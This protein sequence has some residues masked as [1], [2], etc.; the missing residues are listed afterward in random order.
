MI[1]I[2]FIIIGIIIL[3]FKF[4]ELLFNR[5]GKSNK[6]ININSYNFKNQKNQNEIKGGL[7]IENT[8]KCLLLQKIV[9]D[10]LSLNKINFKLSVD[11]IF[12]D[13]QKKEFLKYHEIKEYSM[14]FKYLNLNYDLINN[15]DSNKI[16]NLFVQYMD[17]E[18]QINENKEELEEN[19]I[20]QNS[21]LEI[22]KNELEDI[23]I[24]NKISKK[25]FVNILPSENIQFSN[26]TIKKINEKI[27]DFY[28]ENV[29]IK[30]CSEYFNIIYIKNI[31]NIEELLKLYDLEIINKKQARIKNILNLFEC[32]RFYNLIIIKFMSFAFFKKNNN[33]TIII[34][35]IAH[36]KRF[37]YE[38][39][40][41]NLNSEQEKINLK[42]FSNFPSIDENN[43]NYCIDETLHKEIFDKKNL[44]G[45]EF[46]VKIINEI[47][48]MLF[49][50]DEEKEI[51]TEL[52]TEINAFNE[53]LS[54]IMNQNINL[55]DNPNQIGKTLGY[56][57]KVYI[58]DFLFKRIMKYTSNLIVDLIEIDN[59]YLEINDNLYEIF[60]EKI[61]NSLINNINI[62]SFE[63]KKIDVFTEI[64]VFKFYFENIN[65]NNE[66][67]DDTNYNHL[68]N[69]IVKIVEEKAYMNSYE[70]IYM[71]MQKF[72]YDTNF[73]QTILDLIEEENKNIKNN[74]QILMIDFDKK[75][76][77]PE[78]F[79]IENLQKIN[80]LFFRLPGHATIVIIQKNINE[81]KINLLFFNPHEYFTLEENKDKNK[82]S[83]LFNNFVDKFKKLN[84]E[85]KNIHSFDSKLVSYKNLQKLFELSLKNQYIGMC[86]ITSFL[87]TYLIIHISLSIDIDISNI[88]LIN[89]YIFNYFNKQLFSENF[90]FIN[91]NRYN[92][93]EI[94]LEKKENLEEN[95]NIINYYD[96][97]NN[98]NLLYNNKL[99]LLSD[100]KMRQLTSKLLKKNNYNLNFIL[101]FGIL[102]IKKYLNKYVNLNKF[103]PSTKMFDV[104]LSFSDNDILQKI[105][106]RIKIITEKYSY[107]EK[108]LNLMNSLKKIKQNY[109]LKTIYDMI[110]QDYIN[111][112]SIEYLFYTAEQKFKLT[113]KNYI[114]EIN[115]WKNWNKNKILTWL[116]FI[117]F[118][119]YFY[120][121]YEDENEFFILK[122]DNINNNLYKFIY[123]IH[124]KF[125]LNQI[126]YGFL[127]KNN[128]FENNEF[129]I[130]L[131]DKQKK[132][133]QYHLNLLCQ[134]I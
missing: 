68:K 25:E 84:N 85:E 10:L 15:Y 23:N 87:F 40:K 36:I 134:N 112:N 74:F 27:N 99:L 18:K 47:K 67:K 46:Y 72:K 81:N 76:S 101:N 29:I 66:L 118:K 21:E 82:Y 22:I 69:D 4:F 2:S 131:N 59:E 96:E 62:L 102:I 114:N 105:Q 6:D 95:K 19:I 12:N 8:K 120:K 119:E 88:S 113:Y 24:C 48:N 13:T 28:V 16:N 91:E 41:I 39:N 89:K 17:D 133:F 103:F 1:N 98:S 31:K 129:Y 30:L 121:T 90:K 71:N 14:E 117:V 51:N 100:P 80:L 126:I 50:N 54:L 107:E 70:F 11:K 132:K 86:L 34:H 77:L 106:Y 115:N 108:D 78:N 43:I 49:K 3:V 5:F 94:F 44:F 122:Y 7:T 124:K 53:Q 110:Y 58:I 116:V 52:N 64:D 111:N 92:N 73:Y 42:E 60:E 125:D 9:L 32:F 130:L 79:K 26:Y 57:F 65:Y 63:E 61:Q 97:L 109:E 127:D 104:V 37:L 56:L 20:L 75:T 55:K 123:E 83:S 128:N 35:K 93:N 38:Y 33:F 45:N